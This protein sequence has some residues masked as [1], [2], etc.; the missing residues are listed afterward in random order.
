[1]RLSGQQTSKTRGTAKLSR[2]IR[3]RRGIAAIEFAF[4]GPI[5]IL[6]MFGIVEYGRYLWVKV[7]I[8]QGVEGAARYGVFQNK[9]FNDGAISDWVTP[10]KAYAQA[11]LVGLENL[12]VTVT[13]NVVTIAGVGMVQVQAQYTFNPIIPGLTFMIPGTVTIVARQALQ[14]IGC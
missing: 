8:E 10:T 4:I 5:L 1:M 9:L 14:C 2:L 13:P 12:T 6:L 3:C 7:T 11:Q